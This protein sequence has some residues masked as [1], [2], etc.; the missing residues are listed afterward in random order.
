M[1]IR[2]ITYIDGHLKNYIKFSHFFN[3]NFLQIFNLIRY[4]FILTIAKNVIFYN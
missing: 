3:N 4:K 1:K 2:S